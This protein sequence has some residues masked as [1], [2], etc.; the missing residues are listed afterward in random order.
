MAKKK[1]QLL[2][3]LEKR[4]NTIESSIARF[5]GELEKLHEEIAQAS[6]EGNANSINKLSKKIHTCQ[7]EIENL[8]DQL[9]DATKDFEVEK[10]RFDRDNEE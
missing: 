2:K 7:G 3:P 9:A 5:E 10:A 6:T 4:V 8:Y 1:A